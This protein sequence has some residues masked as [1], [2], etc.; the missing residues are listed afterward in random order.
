MDWSIKLD[1]RRK[2]ASPIEIDWLREGE[3]GNAKL[4][5]EVLEHGDEYDLKCKEAWFYARLASGAIVVEEAR[6]EDGK[7]HYN[8]PPEIASESG[9]VL[10]YFAFKSGDD[11]V[12][13]TQSFTFKTVEDIDIDVDHARYYIPELDKLLGATFTVGSVTVGEDGKAS[14][15]NSGDDYNM[16]L[17]FVVPQG[18]RGVGIN[19]VV[20]TVIAKEDDAYNTIRVNYTTGDHTSFVVKNGSKG[21]KG[22]KGDPFTYDDFTP[23]Q[24]AAL[25]GPQ[26]PA[27]PQGI[28]GKK[29]DTGA[30][31]VGITSISQTKGSNGGGGENIITMELS[32]GEVKNFS[33]Y[34]GRDGKD[35]EDGVDIVNIKHVQTTTESGG[36][37]KFEVVLSDGNSFPYSLYNGSRGPRG[38]GISSVETVESSKDG[39]SNR[40]D[41]FLTNGTV[42]SFHVR[43]G[44]K[45]DKGDPGSG[46]GVTSWNDLEDR[47]FYEELVDAVLL[48]ETEFETEGASAANYPMTAGTTYTVTFNGVEYQCVAVEVEG[49]VAV[50]N[51]G[52]LGIEGGS[53]EPFLVAYSKED[54]A[55][56]FAG[57]GSDTNTIKLSGQAYE[58]HKLDPKFLPAGSTVGAAVLL[59]GAEVFND[60]D[61]NVATGVCSHAEGSGTVA[62]GEY[63]HAEGL[64]TSAYGHATHAEGVGTSAYS[65]GSHAEGLN[66]SASGDHSHAEGEGAI[67]NGYASHA[68]GRNASATGKASHAEGESTT[69]SGEHAHAEGWSTT[70]S[71][72]SAHAEGHSTSA[73]GGYSHAEGDSTIASSWNQHVQGKY[74]IEDAGGIYAHIVGNGSS[75]TNVRSNA[76][77]LDWDGN[78]WFAGSVLV[79][80]TSQD[81]ASELATKAYVDEMLGVIENGYY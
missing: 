27:G 8:M 33:V 16:V 45:G 14:V 60:Y 5:V 68:E 70:A 56:A 50:G 63:A 47:P 54:N 80:G 19:S 41:F 6:V 75:V 74:N 20:Q 55:F 59:N 1:V 13:T 26:G 79:G 52:A 3:K 72:E 29:G 34:N 39:G 42:E 15:T 61:G 51:L 44:S 81:D 48:D 43:N 10:A 30:R 4:V 78:A 77:T 11:F 18:P 24:L 57:F 17:D 37:N 58:V 62:E 73:S 2:Q 64:G 35:G 40:I 12:D 25:T 66:S 28:Q 32:T 67:A 7:V 9:W 49:I 69:A 71:G 21:S 46:G 65:S 22:E 23:E 76:H 36:E 53:D 31:G 38:V